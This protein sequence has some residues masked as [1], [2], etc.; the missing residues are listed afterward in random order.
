V[1]ELLIEY[2]DGKRDTKCVD[3]YSIKDGC[4]VYYIRFGVNS[5]TH[6]I[7]MDIIANFSARR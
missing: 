5:G 1:I 4:L 6:Y 3:D 2:R 7:P